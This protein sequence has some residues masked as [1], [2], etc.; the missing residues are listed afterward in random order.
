MGAAEATARERAGA[1]SPVDTSPAAIFALT[2]AVGQSSTCAGLV[3]S[4]AA[5][6]KRVL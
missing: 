5:V 4:N 3:V 1:D 2:T 6:D